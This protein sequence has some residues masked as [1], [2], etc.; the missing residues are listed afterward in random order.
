MAFLRHATPKNWESREFPPNAGDGAVGREAA[1]DGFKNTT[2]AGI[3]TSTSK[4]SDSSLLLA[5]KVLSRTPRLNQLPRH[6]KILMSIFSSLPAFSTHVIYGKTRT[7]HS[8]HMIW[9]NEVGKDI[10]PGDSTG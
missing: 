6:R 8:T 4:R 5:M 3:L 1:P 10:H 2:A 7:T 9:E